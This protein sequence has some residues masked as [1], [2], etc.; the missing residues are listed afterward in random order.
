MSPPHP[1]ASSRSDSD[2]ESKSMPMTSNLGLLDRPGGDSRRSPLWHAHIA[3]A[4]I[5]RFIQNIHRHER[6]WAMKPPTSGPLIDVIA[7]TAD[8]YA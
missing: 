3:I 1:R 6:V 2:P 8:M 4:P 5:G 7:Q